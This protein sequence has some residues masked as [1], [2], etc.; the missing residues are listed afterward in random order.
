MCVYVCLYKILIYFTDIN[1]IS[2]CTLQLFHELHVSSFK[3]LFCD[4]KLNIY[5]NWLFEMLSI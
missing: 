1:R 4:A 2:S 3:Q 5:S